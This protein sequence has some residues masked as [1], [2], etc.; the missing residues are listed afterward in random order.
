MGVFEN[1]KKFEL[2]PAAEEVNQKSGG[3]INRHLNEL[4]SELRLGK[5]FILTDILDEY[6]AV[7]LTSFGSK[8]A[9]YNPLESLDEGRENIRWGVGAGVGLLRR[10]GCA[11]VAVD[12]AGA[13]DAAAEAAHLAAWRFQ[14]FRSTEVKPECELSLYG[15]DGEQEWRVGSVMG[16]GQNWAR[17]LSDMPANRM[18]PV[19]LAQAALDVLCPLGLLVEVFDEQWCREQRMEAL[20]AVGGGSCGR[21]LVLQCRYEGAGD[22]RPPTL[23]TAKG[24]TF[25]SGGL[26]LKGGEAMRENRGSMAGAAVVLAALRILATLKVPLN[27][28]AVIPLCENMVSGQCMKVGDV[29]QALNGL[30]IQIENTDMEGRLMLADALVYGQAVHKPSLV[31]DVATL[32]H[33]VLLGTGGGAFGC[34]SNV[35]ALWERAREAGAAAGDRPWRLPLWDYYHRQ[36]T[37]DP[38]VDLR[39]KGSGKATPCLGAAFLKRFVCCDWLH[40][41]ITGVGKVGHRQAPPYLHARRM[42]GRPTR[43]LAAL[44]RRLAHDNSSLQQ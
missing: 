12:A 41:D 44:L 19:D 43:T 2:T 24:V 35:G 22:Q 4:A 3:K 1:E 30:S 27:L 31:I 14:E 33:G 39:N 25:D 42:T 5:A 37:D 38:S 6:S 34:F 7:A 20:L 29:V 32:T 21:T 18:T 26:C 17:F 15:A 10:R 13:P 40:W 11:G 16:R 36:I 28:C 23:L 8:T 9:G